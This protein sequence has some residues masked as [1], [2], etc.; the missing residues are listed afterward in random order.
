LASDL[1]TLVARDLIGAA[2]LNG[3]RGVFTELELLG[4]VLGD[5]SLELLLLDLGLAGGQRSG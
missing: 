1:A 5:H 4:D 2:H 3:L